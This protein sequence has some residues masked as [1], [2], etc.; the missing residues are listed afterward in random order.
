MPNV[1]G[2]RRTPSTTKLMKPSEAVTPTRRRRQVTT[3]DPVLFSV[4]QAAVKLG[5]SYQFTLQLIRAGHLKAVR[6]PSAYSKSGRAQPYQVT[7]A[8]V[9]ALIDQSAL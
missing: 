6:L 1:Q 8:A 7:S 4:R 3:P 9:D 5:R 2:R